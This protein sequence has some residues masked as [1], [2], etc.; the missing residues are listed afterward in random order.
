[1]Q[2]LHIDLFSLFDKNNGQ[3]A[4]PLVAGRTESSPTVFARF[5]PVI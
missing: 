5:L 3:I 4:S 2:A 1:M